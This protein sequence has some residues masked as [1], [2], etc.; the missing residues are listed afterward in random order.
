[1]EI[2]NSH[3]EAIPSGVHRVHPK[4]GGA[5]AIPATLTGRDYFRDCLCWCLQTGAR[6]PGEPW[7]PR[8]CW[9]RKRRRGEGMG[10]LEG[11]KVWLRGPTFCLLSTCPIWPHPFCFL[12]PSNGSGRRFLIE[13]RGMLVRSICRSRGCWDCSRE[14]WALESGWPGFEFGPQLD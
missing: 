8:T 14:A 7:T 11:R 10:K 9:W 6:L 13:K 12:V 2:P 3:S 4:P 5:W 1:M